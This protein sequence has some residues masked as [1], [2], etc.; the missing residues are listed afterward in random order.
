MNLTATFRPPSLNICARPQSLKPSTGTPVARDL[1]ERDPYTGDYSVI[2]SGEAQVLLTKDLRMTDNV[3]VEP[4]P[5]NYGLIT[6]NGSVI[7]VS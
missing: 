4:I 5:S 7:T 1:V 2:P 6:W 3:T